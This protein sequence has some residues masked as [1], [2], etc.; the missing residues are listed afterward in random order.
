M[1]IKDGKCLMI[2]FKTNE[3]DGAVFSEPAPWN[4]IYSIKVK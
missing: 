4:M 1:G 3:L 2:E